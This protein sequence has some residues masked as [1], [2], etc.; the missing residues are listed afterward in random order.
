MNFKLNYILFQIKEN[1]LQA[2]L[3]INTIL[4]ILIL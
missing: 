3:Y 4:Q 2:K 1:R